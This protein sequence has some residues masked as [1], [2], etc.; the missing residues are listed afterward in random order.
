MREAK[1][2]QIELQVEEWVVVPRTAEAVLTTSVAM[3]RIIG[4]TS[5]VAVSASIAVAIMAQAFSA[6]SRRR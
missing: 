2:G 3:S 4:S 5:I 1:V 6:V